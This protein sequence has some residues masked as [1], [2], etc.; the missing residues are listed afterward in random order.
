MNALA[1]LGGQLSAAADHDLGHPAADQHEHQ[2]GA[3]RGRGGASAQAVD[4]PADPLRPPGPDPVPTGRDET[5]GRIERHGGHGGAGAGRRAEDP[6]GRMAG[7]EDRRERQDEHE[8]RDDETQPA[9]NGPG[10]TPQTPGAVDGQLRRC[11]AGEQ[12]HG[13]DGLF[14]LLRLDPLSLLDA[15]ATEQGDVGRR[16]PEPDAPETEPLFRDRAE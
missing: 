14:E 3:D 8:S 2:V 9:E 16:S 4:D 6:I 7:Q 5:P 12:I 13:G 1:E 10:R 11:G 15:E